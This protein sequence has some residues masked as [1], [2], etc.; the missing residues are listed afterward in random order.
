[1]NKPPKTVL[2]SKEGDGRA[3]G[4]IFLKISQEKRQGKKEKNN[5]HRISEAPAKALQGEITLQ[6]EAL[7]RDFQSHKTNDVA[8]ILNSHRI[9][10][11]Y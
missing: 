8:D 7:T 3:A 9:F 10:P 2:A 6:S 1:M 5:L 4:F 11:P